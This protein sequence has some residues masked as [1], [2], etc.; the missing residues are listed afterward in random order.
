MSPT[1]DGVVQQESQKSTNKH[2]RGQQHLDDLVQLRNPYREAKVTGI[3][4]WA[5]DLDR[6]FPKEDVQMTNEYM[7][8]VQ[9][10]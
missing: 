7:K 4:K 6:D 5:E 8:G 3:T 2:A 9:H 1:R 10:R